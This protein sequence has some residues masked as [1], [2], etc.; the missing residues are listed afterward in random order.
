MGSTWMTFSTCFRFRFALIRVRLMFVFFSSKL[1]VKTL[2][3]K[4]KLNFV[5]LS[6]SFSLNMYPNSAQILIILIIQLKGKHQWH[7]KYLK[8][9]CKCGLSDSHSKITWLGHFI[10]SSITK[11]KNRDFRFSFKTNLLRKKKSKSF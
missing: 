2:L 9:S 4:K 5:C 1:C 10:F 7:D 3:H 6:L 11:Y 8:F